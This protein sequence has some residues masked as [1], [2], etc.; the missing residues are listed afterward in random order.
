MVLDLQWHRILNAIS[1]IFLVLLLVVVGVYHISY[2]RFLTDRIIQIYF[3][4]VFYG[5]CS[6]LVLAGTR[7]RFSGTI[8]EIRNFFPVSIIFSI[9]FVTII[10][11]FYFL[12][13][14]PVGG[15]EISQMIY[16]RDFNPIVGAL[17]QQQPPLA[18]FISALS[19]RLGGM[20]IHS[21]RGIGIVVSSFCLAYLLGLFKLLKL[22]SFAAVVLA[23]VF[24]SQSMIFQFSIEFRPYLLGI[25]LFLMLVHE[26]TTAFSK[27]PLSLFEYFRLFAWA[28]LF[29]L[30]LGFQPVVILT[31]LIL[32]LWFSHRSQ[33]T[34]PLVAAL[35]VF[36]PI[37]FAINKESGQYFSFDQIHLLA[38]ETAAAIVF[39]FLARKV[40]SKEKKG[41]LFVLTTSLILF[42]A[43]THLL[44]FQF[45]TYQLNLRYV[46]IALSIAV[47]VIG[48]ICVSYNLKD[49]QTAAIALLIYVTFVFP[50][51]VPQNHAARVDRNESFR[52]L[53]EQ[54]QSQ[55]G[56]FIPICNGRAG[57]WDY[58]YILQFL[59]PQGYS[60]LDENL[61]NPV[62]NALKKMKNPEKS[63]IIYLYVEHDAQLDLVNLPLYVKKLNS[64]P[65]SHLFKLDGS[66]NWNSA[67]QLSKELR[68]NKEFSV[69]DFMQLLI[70]D[71]FRKES[72]NLLQKLQDYT[73]WEYQSLRKNLEL[74]Q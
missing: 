17:K 61:K 2:F 1:I 30:S 58:S 63:Q 64:T 66:D 71:D 35:L 47:L 44:F 34:I 40:I 74:P 31:S 56:I 49:I 27:E 69:I 22:S 12:D 43:I 14:F 45:I 18:Y 48:L 67:T 21:I 52:L 8:Y 23:T 33:L 16:S 36:L 25:T 68:K 32:A 5:C 19:E 50:T 57:C 59:A 73:G 72:V 39:M 28:V 6:V 55:Q 11:K 24:F 29:C 41:L 37:Q 15:D 54:F 26:M 60:S 4:V 38:F 13:L 7:T 9:F 20:S 10:L 3:F 53:I 70:H 65:T 42:L 46:C 51:Y 62:E